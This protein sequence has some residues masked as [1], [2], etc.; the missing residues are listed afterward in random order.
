MSRFS[1]EKLKPYFSRPIPESKIIKPIDGLRFISIL[2][3]IITHSSSYALEYLLNDDTLK[4][5]ENG[6]GGVHMF[7]AISGFVLSHQLLNNKIKFSYWGYLRRRFE[8]IEPPLF[9]TAAIMVLLQILLFG[10]PKKFIESYFYVITYISSYFNMNKL[11]AVYW[12]LDVE[13]A[14]YVFLPLFWFTINKRIYLWILIILIIEFFSLDV[15]LLPNLKFFIAGILV[16]ILSIK[17]NNNSIENRFSIN[18]ITSL[19][20]ILLFFSR[21]VIFN[22]YFDLIESFLLFCILYLVIIHRALNSILSQNLVY[23]L[24][25]GCYIIYLIHY[26]II[27]GIGRI[28]QK[29]NI[30]GDVSG[31]ILW[32]LLVVISLFASFLIFPILERPFMVKKWWKFN[33]I[34]LIL[35]PESGKNT[36]PHQ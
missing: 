20:I 29:I 21:H 5:F 8:R 13:F 16:S 33:F 11:L 7:F 2:I 26:P 9:I 30:F 31:Y 12:S 25:S 1:F 36:N 34:T 22:H 3:V 10:E 6:H 19:L 27:S 17:I 18:A 24:G 15:P 35:H 23:R 28:F 14:F 32:L 4:Y